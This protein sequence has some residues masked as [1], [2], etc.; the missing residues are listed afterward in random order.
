MDDAMKTFTERPENRDTGSCAAGL[1]VW[2]LRTEEDYLRA[3]KVVD[4]LAVKGED[5]L[6][7][8]EADRLDI[9]T[10]PME[11]YEEANHPVVPPELTPIETLE[12]LMEES[13]MTQSDLGRLL[14]DRTLGHKIMKG[15]RSLS[16]KQIRILSEHFKID[17]M[18]F[19]G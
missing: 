17:P 19:F 2:P 5:N 1:Q 18:S 3:Q 13:G 12:Y 4:E 6:D 8:T 10:T 14:G 7:D 11:T 9:F 15:D 16:K